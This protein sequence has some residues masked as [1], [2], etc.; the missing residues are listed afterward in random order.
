MRPVKI[1]D[2]PVV[3]SS[4]NEGADTDLA[5]R[6]VESFVW[7]TSYAITSP[8]LNSLGRGFHLIMYVVS[9]IFSKVM[10]SGEALGSEKQSNRMKKHLEKKIVI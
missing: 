10:L 6:E 5:A 8:L 4:R 9:F 7:F 1:K 3:F 2:V